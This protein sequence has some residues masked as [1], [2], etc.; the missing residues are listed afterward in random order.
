MNRRAVPHWLADR[1]KPRHVPD[2]CFALGVANRDPRTIVVESEPGHGVLNRSG[3]SQ[4][5]WPFLRPRTRSGRSLSPATNV[6]AIG[7]EA[8]RGEPSRSSGSAARSAREWRHQAAAPPRRVPATT[9]IVPAG[10]NASSNRSLR[11]LGHLPLAID[12]VVK[13]SQSRMVPSGLPV[14]MAL[15]SGRRRERSDLGSNGPSGCRSP[16]HHP[17]AR[18]ARCCLRSP[19]GSTVRRH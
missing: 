14:A 11:G 7:A 19:S 5:R 4:G 10:S 2:P 1:L 8:R 15:P 18:F 13:A 12:R 3:R 9:S 6:R 16:A 17:V